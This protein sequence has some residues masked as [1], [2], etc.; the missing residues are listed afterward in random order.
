MVLIKPTSKDCKCEPWPLAL[1]TLEDERESPDGQASKKLDGL[2][3]G[4]G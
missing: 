2:G 1:E 3:V 4:H